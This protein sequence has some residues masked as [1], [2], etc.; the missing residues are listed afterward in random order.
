MNA[1]P[2]NSFIHCPHCGCSK[3]IISTNRSKRCLECNF[4][5]FANI[6]SCV[7]II[8]TD[9]SGNILLIKRRMEP[10]KGLIDFPGGFVE[11]GE[12]LNEAAA[13]ELFEETGVIVLP[14]DM[15]YFISL[16]DSYIYSSVSVPVMTTFFK[17]KV[18]TLDSLSA[19]DDA[20]ECLVADIDSI[21]VGEFAFASSA[22]AFNRLK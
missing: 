3:F 12:S 9:Q 1:H 2:L 20:D 4:E 17:A 15:S 21:D 8:I 7:A 11:I 5:Y 14:E 19:G 13:R 10:S 16:P 6:A 18:D 22:E